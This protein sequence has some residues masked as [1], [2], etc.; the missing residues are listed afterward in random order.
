MI[1]LGFLALVGVSA[2]LGVGNRAVQY[3]IWA[4]WLILSVIFVWAYA[5]TESP[6]DRLRLID[7]RGINLLPQPLRRWVFDE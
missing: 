6:A 5:R 7:K 1:F 2:A 3:G 4:F